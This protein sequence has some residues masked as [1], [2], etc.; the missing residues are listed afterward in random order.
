MLRLVSSRFM[1]SCFLPKK[2]TQMAVLLCVLITD[3]LFL[4]SFVK[5][6]NYFEIVGYQ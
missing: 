4:P 3:L 6:K 1:V 5:K 2:L